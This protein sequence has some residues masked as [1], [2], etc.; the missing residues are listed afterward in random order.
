MKIALILLIPVILIGCS[1][2]QPNK[3][4][5]NNPLPEP[6]TIDTVAITDST[7]F[8]NYTVVGDTAYFYAKADPNTKM[9]TYLTKDEWTIICQEKGEF[10]YAVRSLDSTI[11]TPMWTDPI[12][13][14]GW[15][16][17][18]DLEQLL[19]TPPKIVGE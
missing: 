4:A 9:S 2:K 17:L 19:F 6:L 1:Q 16:R 15:L 7:H 12:K 10:G 8:D 3:E 5:K 11:I 14:L 18:R 13:P